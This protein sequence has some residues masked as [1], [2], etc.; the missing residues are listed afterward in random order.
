MQHVGQYA[1]RVLHSSPSTDEDDMSAPLQRSIQDLESVVRVA[2][3][4]LWNPDHISQLFREE[5]AG[6]ADW[7]QMRSGHHPS[8]SNTQS[9]GIPA[10]PV[11]SI[12]ASIGLQH[13]NH[14]KSLVLR[15][16]LEDAIRR[17][18]SREWKLH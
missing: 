2:S 16:H 12:Y 18:G 8:S 10:P 7:S 17:V 4:P 15:I 6:R 9:H 5:M 14:N 3:R 11:G 13:L 1:V